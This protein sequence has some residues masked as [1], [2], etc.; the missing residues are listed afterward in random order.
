MVKVWTNGCFDVL[1]RGH[2]EMLKYAKS[3]GD[4]LVVGVDTDMKVKEDKGHH[5]PFNKL[6]DR[7]E[8]LLALRYV[9]RVVSFDS[10]ENLEKSIEDYEPDYIVV[11]A[12]WRGKDVVGSHH[13][14]QVC[15]FERVGDLSTTKILGYLK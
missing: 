6:E 10:R 14:K 13:S 8:I 3:L 2:I 9:D 7:I 11:G 15:F 12:D 4:E 1:H 5:R